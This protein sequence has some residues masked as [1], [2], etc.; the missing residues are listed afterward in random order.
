MGFSLPFCAKGERHLGDKAIEKTL[1]SEPQVL[2]G[3]IITTTWALNGRG[4]RV[5]SD[6]VIYSAP[7]IEDLTSHSS[8]STFATIYEALPLLTPI[9][10]HLGNSATVITT[11]GH[12]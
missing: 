4:L 3:I 10:N 11:L 2:A 8:P 9:M 5:M 12:T 1:W 6:W 7:F